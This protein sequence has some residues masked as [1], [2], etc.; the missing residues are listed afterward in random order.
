MNHQEALLAAQMNLFA[1]R[2]Y[3]TPEQVRAR[4]LSDADPNV[5][6][7]GGIDF[8]FQYHPTRYWLCA[9]ISLSTHKLE[10]DAL[11]PNLPED[12]A[13]K[14]RWNLDK[15]YAHYTKIGTNFKEYVRRHFHLTEIQILDREHHPP[16]FWLTEA[17]HHLRTRKS[18]ISMKH[19]NS[20]YIN[21]LTNVLLSVPDVRSSGVAISILDE[22]MLV[23]RRFI[24]DNI[25]SEERPCYLLLLLEE[26]AEKTNKETGKKVDKVWEQVRKFAD[27]EAIAAAQLFEIV[28]N[29]G[30]Y[31]SHLEVYKAIAYQADVF[32]DQLALL[33]PLA[34]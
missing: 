23:M 24:S 4:F 30:M 29:L 14:T 17:P 7:H 19:V 2:L 34:A 15:V 12:E 21:T 13:K 18:I 27:I 10:S 8:R 3:L 6:V 31:A 32:W 11:V 28:S 22:Q 5:P 33:L 16:R 1:C 20:T 25:L 9:T 26:T